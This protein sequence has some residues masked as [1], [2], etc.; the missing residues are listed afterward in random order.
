MSASNP[1]ALHARPDAEFNVR[2]LRPAAS[3]AR[4][5]LAPGALDDICARAGISRDALLNGNAAW[6]SHEQFESVLTSI[7]E[8]VVSDDAFMQACAYRIEDGYGAFRFLLWATSPGAIYEL[9]A[10]TMHVVSS[11]SNY[12]IVERGRTHLRLRYTTT[13]PESR[14][15]CLSRQA[16]GAALPMLWDL[17]RAEYSETTCVARGDACCEYLIRWADRPRWLASVVGAGVGVGLTAL[18]AAAHQLA[19]ATSFAFPLAGAIAGYAFELRRAGSAN[20]RMREEQ[21]AAVRQLAEEEAEARRELIALSL[22]QRDWSRMLEEAAAERTAAMRR[23]VDQLARVQ[24]ER[25]VTLRGFSHDLRNPLTVLKASVS[26]LRDGFVA[27]GADRDLFITDLE[28]AINQMVRL[29]E[30]LMKAATANREIVELAPTPI[31]VSTFVDRLRRRV[32]ALVHGR[33]IRV[34]VFRTREAPDA[35]ETDPFLLDRLVD[36]LLT[37]AAKY[38]DRGSIVI[39]VDG[40]PTTMTL[41]VSD[42][43]RGIHPEA[44]SRTFEPGGS[45][46]RTRA[47][48]SYGVGLSVVVQLLEQVGGRLEVM[49]KPGSGTTFWVHLPLTPALKLVSPPPPTDGELDDRYRKLLN[50]VVTIRRSGGVR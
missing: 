4:D 6:V 29:L 33:D 48:D 46:P 38:T 31:D 2:L 5:K 14:L 19:P 27:Q 35:L 23:M 32:R 49:S 40:S 34:S 24:E 36:N 22:R 17:P 16:A 28:M 30:E 45:D 10:R 42:T 25:D 44:L 26:M 50:K 7:R 15:M 8:A 1:R 9:A 13:R 43:G 18:L 12:E 41:K 3:F 11:V 39:E 37:N 20:L 21:S 47:S